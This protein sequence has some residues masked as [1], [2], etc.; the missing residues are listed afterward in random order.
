MRHREDLQPL[1]EV[2]GSTFGRLF[3]DDPGPFLHALLHLAP[4]TFSVERRG[5][6]VVLTGDRSVCMALKGLEDALLK[7]LASAGYGRI[8]RISW[9][10]R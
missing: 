10:S 2:A 8:R 3:P 6:E 4:G 1:G 5:E 7:R 9:R